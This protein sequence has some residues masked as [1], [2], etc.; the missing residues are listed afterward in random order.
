SKGWDPKLRPASAI[1]N[2]RCRSVRQT[3]HSNFIRESPG[4]CEFDDA[5]MQAMA[6]RLIE[7][8]SN[9]SR[10]RFELV[11]KQWKFWRNY[12]YRVSLIRH[13]ILSNASEGQSFTQ[14]VSEPEASAPSKVRIHDDDWERELLSDLSEYELVTEKNGK[15]EDQWETEIKELLNTVE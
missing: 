3:D 5:A 7:I 13:S 10:I 15:S 9:L 2:Q 11:P 14:R 12:F 4:E 1:K 6:K 8:D